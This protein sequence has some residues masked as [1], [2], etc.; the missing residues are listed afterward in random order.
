MLPRR[1]RSNTFMLLQS[2][3]NDQINNSWFCLY[4][5]TGADMNAILWNDEINNK[6][7]IILLLYSA[8]WSK[9]RN[10]W[11]LTSYRDFYRCVMQ[12]V[13]KMLKVHVSE[14]KKSAFS[15]S[16]VSFSFLTQMRWAL[17]EAIFL[18]SSLNNVA[19]KVTLGWGVVLQKRSGE[20]LPHWTRLVNDND[21]SRPFS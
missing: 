18:S 1:V 13:I 6:V 4:A 11:L 9:I 3:M 14:S 17:R 8:Q 16:V 7:I 21:K 20:L 12:M 19:Q 15:S 10:N 5:V 2:F